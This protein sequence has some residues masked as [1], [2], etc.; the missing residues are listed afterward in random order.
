MCSGHSPLRAFDPFDM[1]YLDALSARVEDPQD[2]LGVI[3]GHPHYGSYT[4]KVGHANHLADGLHIEGGMLHVNERAIESGSSD[5]FHHGGVRKSD[6]AD[7]SQSAFPHYSLD[8]VLFH[9]NIP[10][11]N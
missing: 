6:V 11:W 2:R 4:A 3:L 10:R 8:A 5:D 1:R 7:D 9:Y